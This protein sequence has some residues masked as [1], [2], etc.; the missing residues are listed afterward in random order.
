[1]IGARPILER[2]SYIARQLAG[3]YPRTCRELAVAL[4]VCD[5]T[6]LRDIEFMRDRL[7]LPIASSPR[8]YIF[9]EKLHLCPLCQ[10][11]QG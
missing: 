8:G 2:F 10:R 9:T 3:G 4:E 1:M 6:V 7:R 5:K 11:R